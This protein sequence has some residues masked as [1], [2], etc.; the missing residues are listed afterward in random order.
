[1]TQ[2]IKL[3]MVQRSPQQVLFRRW[4]PPLRAGSS[5][6]VSIFQVTPLWAQ[7]EGAGL[8]AAPPRCPGGEKFLLKENVGAAQ[9]GQTMCWTDG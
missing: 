3:G 1:M 8:K 9:E 2:P 5:S 4:A 7:S 6:P